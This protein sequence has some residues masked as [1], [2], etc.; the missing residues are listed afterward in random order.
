MKKTSKLLLAF[1]CATGIISGLQAG[2]SKDHWQ[3]LA[4]LQF[5]GG[6]PTAESSARLFDELDFQRA[7]QVY[8]WA[9]PAMNIDAMRQ[10]SEAAF[11]AGNHILPVWKDR[12]NTKTRVTTPNSDVV[13]AMSYLDLKDGPVVVEVPPKLQGMFD[14]FW[15]RPIADVGFVGPD[16][17]EGGKYLLLPP[18]YQGDEP[19]GFFTF[20]SPTYR[21]FLFWRG[22]LVDGKTGDAVKLIEQ[23]RVY[24]LGKKDSAPAMVFPNASDDAGE[25][26]GHPGHQLL[27]EPEAIHR[28][29]AGGPRGLRHAGNDGDPRH[30]QGPAV[31]TR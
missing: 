10:G 8:L 26:A 14:D 13:Y 17:G 1:V 2:T 4:E 30:R 24:P 9:L 6:Y 15:H 21:V 12:L 18:G 25:Y 16:K 23:T 3:N 20:R 11:G 22:F 19:E 5:P 31:R 27:R 7:V 28:L 29:R